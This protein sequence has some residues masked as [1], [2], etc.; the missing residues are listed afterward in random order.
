[1][2]LRILELVHGGLLDNT[3]MTKRYRIAVHV[4]S[5]LLTYDRDIYYRHPDLFT[6]QTVVDRYVDDLAYTLGITRSQLNVVRC[7]AFYSYAEMLI[8]M[9][10][11][12]RRKG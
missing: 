7:S 11:Q 3:I 12:L 10:R 1:M 5:L 9:Y 2:L 6:K 4:A 8:P